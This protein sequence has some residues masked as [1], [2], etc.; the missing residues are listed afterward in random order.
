MR[1]L[2]ITALLLAA[3]SGPGPS[4][5][6][7]GP[8]CV[9]DDECDDGLFCNGAER[10]AARAP[11]A[12]P[13]GCAPAEAPPC[14][15][16]CSEE[17]DRCVDEC[18]DADG[19][20]HAETSCGGDDCDDQDA[21]RFPGSVEVC[22]PA[23]HDEDCDPTTFG[24][25][26]GDGDTFTSASCCNGADGSRVC[27]D[28]CDDGDPS[29][30]PGEAE[31]CDGRNND[32]DGA[33]DE[34]V[35]RTFYRDAD[36]DDFGD[37]AD[38]VRECQRPALHSDVAGDCD[39]R[40]PSVYMGAREE[41]DLDDDDCDGIVDEGTGA[42]YFL[43]ADGDG[44]GVDST[45][46]TAC[47]RPARHATRGG[48]CDD[49]SAARNPAV[50]EICNG[51]DDDC[52]GA[53]DA[54]GE[55]LDGDG[56]GGAG[57]G[58]GR[59]CDD[60]DPTVYRG[61]PELCDGQDND[62][63]PATVASDD[64]DG[65][66][67]LPVGATCAGGPLA[68]APRDDCDESDPAR[69]GG[70]VESC[71]GVDDD[72][73]GVSDGADATAWCNAPG[74]SP[75]AIAV[76][77]AGTCALTCAT[78]FLDCDASAP[79][80]E[81]DVRTPASCGA[82][83]VTCE[84]G[85]N[86]V[87]ARC[88]PRE[89]WRT[90]MSAQIGGV[91]ADAS[92][93]CQVGGSFVWRLI[94]GTRRL[95]GID[96][97]EV[98]H[99]AWDENGALRWAEARKT[100]GYD[101]GYALALE[102]SGDVLL[103]G[104]LGVT[105]PPSGT[106]ALVEP[107]APATGVS[108]GARTFAP[109]T[110]TSARFLTMLP[111]GGYVVLGTYRDSITIGSATYSASVDAPFLAGFAADGALRWS[112]ALPGGALLGLAADGSSNVYVALDASGPIDLGGGAL[113][114]PPGSA[115][116]LASY[117]GATGAHRWSR[118]ETRTAEGHVYAAGVA[119]TARAS[120][121][122][123]VADAQGILDLGGRLVSTPWGSRLVACFDSSGAYAVHRELLN[124]MRVARGVGEDLLLGGDVGVA[125]YGPDLTVRWAWSSPSSG[126]E[127]ISAGPFNRICVAGYGELV[128]LEE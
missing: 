41:C 24:V 89:R 73:S 14:R 105:S 124:T 91:V 44:Y 6:D 48:D 16:M 58:G 106:A 116:A 4:P 51:V 76:C 98:V 61:A 81:T 36:A 69:H 52:D 26:D 54:P 67:H 71:N 102:P 99:A 75:N 8:R 64:R 37:P 5:A 101:D 42:T 112:R 43:D 103:A 27:G 12:S 17:T 39:D 95:D 46:T 18:P 68:S 109:G 118:Y 123:F 60:G 59:D 9:Q 33:I 70:A 3:C 87:A 55:D 35:L 25:L 128:Q 34:G 93:G 119:L 126:I 7:G 96:G 122:C 88:T 11:G 113:P 38:V 107:R 77:S 79:G 49:A 62:C 72:C 31:T 2:A 111:A 15:G 29:V 94:L 56:Q 53:L 125:R 32:C 66:G 28:D 90:T 45:S 100:A 74:R 10:C 114:S 80:C 1:A 23:G 108:R 20:G 86:C 92:G 85:A 30:H 121:P 21:D 50:A 127:H 78:S 115:L 120:G 65:D 57:C 110:A 63:D 82:C 83:G 84:P 104:R 40:D 47:A 13:D 22:D 117:A 97:T 19:D